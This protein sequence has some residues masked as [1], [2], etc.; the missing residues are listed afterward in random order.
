MKPAI[1]TRRA[2]TLLLSALLAALV[3]TP[4]LAVLGDTPFVGGEVTFAASSATLPI[5]TPSAE[6]STMRARVTARC[7]LVGA[8]TTAASTRR[9]PSLTGS[10][11]A[12]A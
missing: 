5:G 3:G 6:R 1:R 2:A 8:R 11:G 4:A 12:G 9:S 7:S 10:G